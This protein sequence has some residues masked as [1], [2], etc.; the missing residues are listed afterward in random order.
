MTAL[1]VGDRCGSCRVKV[2][3]YN[4]AFNWLVAQGRIFC[5]RCRERLYGAGMTTNAARSAVRKMLCDKSEESLTDRDPDKRCRPCG[6]CGEDEVRGATYADGEENYECDACGAVFY[7][8]PFDY[9][10]ETQ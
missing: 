6:E 3:R 5:W 10:R 4:E 1:K 2:T 8:P 7:R 9:R